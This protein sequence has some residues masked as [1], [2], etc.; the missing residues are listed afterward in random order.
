MSLRGITVVASLKE[1]FNPT[2]LISQDKFILDISGVTCP[3]GNRTMISNYNK[4]EGTTVSYFKEE[5]CNQCSLKD[6]CTKQEGRTITIGKYPEL[7]MKAKEYNIIQ[8]L[9][10]I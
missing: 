3:A 9:R 6:Q 4:K 2:G 10:M 1:D 5:F 7:M 8:D